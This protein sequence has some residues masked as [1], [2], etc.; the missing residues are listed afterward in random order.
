MLSGY[1][2]KRGKTQKK[3]AHFTPPP[4]I[5]LAQQALMRKELDV[6][7]RFLKAARKC[8]QTRQRACGFQKHAYL[9]YLGVLTLQRGQAPRAVTLLQQAKAAWSRETPPQGNTKSDKEDNKSHARLGQTLSFYLGQAY[10]RTKRY[11]QAA[12]TLRDAAGIAQKLSG[13]YRLMALAQINAEQYQN[14]KATLQQGFKRFPQDA[15]MLQ[16]MATLYLRVGAWQAARRI[17]RRL[18][19]LSPKPNA[20]SFLMTID[21]MRQA[22]LIYQVLPLLEEARLYM[23][24]HPGVLLRL[25]ITYSR[26]QMPIAAAQ[27]FSALVPMQPRMAYH[28]AAAW[29]QAGRLHNALFWNRQIRDPAKRAQQRSQLL[30]SQGKF[31]R[32]LATLRLQLDNKTITPQGRYQLA[33]VAIRLGQYSLA[34]TLLTSLKQ[35]AYAASAKTL[36]TTLQLCRATPWRCLD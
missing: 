33:Y 19:R 17:G 5:Q 25:A 21:A 16:L 10:F 4:Y 31:V 29:M 8:W 35:S 15:G 24:K 27:C 9:L 20:S 14:A 1:T 7:A 11:E 12:Q 3:D 13:Y 28:A 34:Q 26:A 6:A 36:E 18:L 30:L 32:A 2:L 22:G 23:P